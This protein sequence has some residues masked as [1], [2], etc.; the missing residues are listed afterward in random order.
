LAK[1]KEANG[2]GESSKAPPR[3]ETVRAI[4]WAGL[5]ALAIRSFVV[6]PFKIPSGSMIPT[7]LVG[8][9]VLVNKFAYGIRLPITGQLLIPVGKP[10]RGDVMVFR[11]PDDPSQD[12]IKRVVGMPGDRIEIRD[13]HVVINGQPIDDKAEGEYKYP[14]NDSAEP[15][16]AQRFLEK[17][18]EGVEYTVL[19][20]I[21]EQAP[22]MEPTGPWIVPADQYFMMGDNRDNSADSRRWRHSFVSPE[23]IKGKAFLIHWSW[24][25]ASNDHENRSFIGDLLFTV[26]RVVTFQ[27]EEIRWNR[28]FH[29]VN[30]PAD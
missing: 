10:A 24:V 5:I 9:Y 19:Q 8:D 2:E 18:P 23:A 4:L 20:F 6:E 7:L 28:I 26:W 17:N 21:P 29:R 22:R 12:F 16:V 1:A 13:R 30:G 11:F 14:A 27:V 3:F 25:V 15:R